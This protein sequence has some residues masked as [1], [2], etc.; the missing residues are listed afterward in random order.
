MEENERYSELAVLHEL[1]ARELRRRLSLFPE[2]LRFYVML[3]D[4]IIGTENS[5][6]MPETPVG[7]LQESEEFVA[8][9]MQLAPDGADDAFRGVLLRLL[10]ETLRGE[11]R[12][13]CLSCRVFNSCLGL[14]NL[15]VG[16][17]FR[18]RAEGDES[19]EL[20]KEITVQ[21][22]AALARTPYIDSDNAHK[23]CGDFA[24]IY[25]RTSVAAVFGRYSSIGASLREEYGLDYGDLQKE[26][27][28]LNM[29]FYEKSGDCRP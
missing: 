9:L 7:V 6:R 29:E 21:V 2:E 19:P 18:R 15:P 4:S 8:G 24:H 14:A 13:N 11:L 28:E 22:E 12:F 17:L 23:L 10:V 26:I 3:A 5:R 20:R 16:D 25:S 1:N 27:I